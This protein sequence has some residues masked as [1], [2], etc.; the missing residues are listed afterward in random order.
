MGGCAC[1]KKSSEED[2]FVSFWDSLDFKRTSLESITEKILLLK[3]FLEGFR[4]K[5]T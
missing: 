2:Y 3:R 1:I 5:N 4:R